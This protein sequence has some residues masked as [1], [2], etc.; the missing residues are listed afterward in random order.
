MC[1]FGLPIAIVSD[2]GT[3]FANA[4]ATNLYQDLGV[5]TKFVYFVHLQAN[6][7]SKSTN[8][9]IFKGLKKNL[10]DAKTNGRNCSTKYYGHI[11]Q[12]Y[13]V[14]SKNSTHHDVW[15][16]FYSTYRY[17]HTLMEMF[18]IW[19]RGKQFR[20]GMCGGLDQ[21]IERSRPCPRILW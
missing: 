14:P 20:I 17:W 9:V 16:I 6:G 19:S 15:S 1:K 11:T 21:W 13:I 4:M 18:L 3:Q 8:K 10:D 12:P 7:K 5:Q 2:K